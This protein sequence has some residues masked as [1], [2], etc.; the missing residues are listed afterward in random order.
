MDDNCIG[1]KIASNLDISFLAKN[2]LS[3][4]YALEISKFGGCWRLVEGKKKKRI[5][6]M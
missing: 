4:L 2:I 3:V 5:S 6:F 1:R